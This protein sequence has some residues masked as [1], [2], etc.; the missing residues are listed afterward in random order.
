M[1][2]ARGKADIGIGGIFLR[3]IVMPQALR[4]Y[5]RVTLE[6]HGIEAHGFTSFSRLEEVTQDST[7]Y[8]E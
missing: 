4:M 1:D 7:T 8:S 3:I 5:A 2:K 6:S